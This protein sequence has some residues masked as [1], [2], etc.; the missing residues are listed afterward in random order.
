MEIVSLLKN[1]GKLARV[2]LDDGSIID[3]VV[4]LYPYG[5]FANIIIDNNSLGLLFCQNTRDY[6]YVIPYNIAKQPV[7]TSGS[8]AI[9]D[10]E[11]NKLIK[12]VNGD[13]VI[14]TN[15]IIEGTFSVNGAVNLGNNLTTAGTANLQGTTT[16]QGKV[17]TTHTH[18]GVQTG[19]STT[20]GVV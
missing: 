3:N 8:V 2:Q 1:D 10:F 18:S 4:I 9:G 15:V 17:F 7:L 11:N 12:I 6:C 19:S 16:I 5:L 13:V 14:N 20:G